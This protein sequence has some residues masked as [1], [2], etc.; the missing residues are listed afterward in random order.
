VK[1]I[2]DYSLLHYDTV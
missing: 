1:R 2:E